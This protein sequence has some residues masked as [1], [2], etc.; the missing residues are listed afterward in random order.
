MSEKTSRWACVLGI[1]I[2][3]GGWAC[4]R[5]DL[6]DVGRILGVEG[7]RLPYTPVPTLPNDCLVA[8]VDVPIG[9]LKDSEARESD[10]GKSGSRDVDRGARMWCRWPGSVA[11]PP[12]K[13]Q[14]RTGLAEHARAARAKDEAGRKRTLDNILP[15]GLSKQGLEL[16]PAID[17]GAKMKRLYPSKVYESHPEVVFGVLAGGKLPVSKDSL[18]GALV[19]AALLAEHLG[20]ECTRWAVEQEAKSGINADNWLDALAMAAV[21]YDLRSL[22]ERKI[23]LGEDG[24]PKNWE[25]QS[26]FI[27]ALPRAK[28]ER[29]KKLQLDPVIA[30]ALGQLPDPTA[31]GDPRRGVAD[32]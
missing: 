5:L 3:E 15:K 16:I 13:G 26:E 23:L 12:T 24:V 9:L 8:I 31:T 4:A 7:L 30:I 2:G 27:M 18:S 14:F 29:P 19:R 20:R 25:E 1:D 22:D 6:D 17:S 10:K 28:A 11:P 21:A 32:R